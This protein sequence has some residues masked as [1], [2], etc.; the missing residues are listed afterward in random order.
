MMLNH[1]CILFASD[2][3]SL[4]PYFTDINHRYKSHPKYAG[5]NM[6]DNSF[7]MSCEIYNKKFLIKL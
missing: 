5:K 7:T 4:S 3:Q 1:P 6:N 2:F